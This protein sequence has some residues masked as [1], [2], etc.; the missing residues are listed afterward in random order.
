MFKIIHYFKY[1]LIIFKFYKDNKICIP[2]L[3]RKAKN[4]QGHNLLGQ[5]Q[6][7]GHSGHRGHLSLCCFSRVA[8]KPTS[9]C[10]SCCGLEEKNL[11]TFYNR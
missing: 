5:G 9:L 4:C 11:L 8:A 6:T 7:Q 2:T 3:Q 10:T 1:I